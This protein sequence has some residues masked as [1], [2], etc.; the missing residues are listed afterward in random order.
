[1]RHPLRTTYREL[2]AQLQQ[3]TDEELDCDVS[4]VD[5]V[6]ECFAVYLSRDGHDTLDEPH[7]VFQI[8]NEE[9]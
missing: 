2:I 7:P 9:G 5:T 1:M 4:V 8:L 3:L 6:D